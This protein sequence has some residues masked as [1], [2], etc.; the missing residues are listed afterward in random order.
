MVGLF[1]AFSKMDGRACGEWTLRFSGATRFITS[2]IDHVQ[3]SNTR[4]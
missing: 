1:R 3:T 2:Y 4:W